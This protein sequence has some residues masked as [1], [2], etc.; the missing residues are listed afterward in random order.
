MARTN[1]DK[2]W[3]STKVTSIQNIVRRMIAIRNFKTK[4]T[5]LNDAALII[6]KQ[7]RSWVSRMILGGRLFERELQV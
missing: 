4:K 3:L 5:Q 2:D 6:Q 7:F 1:Y